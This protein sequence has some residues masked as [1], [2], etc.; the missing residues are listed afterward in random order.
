MQVGNEQ[1]LDDKEKGQCMSAQVESSDWS[2]GFQQG[3]IDPED[4]LQKLDLSG[5]D[6]WDPQLQQEV[7]D[8]I[9]E[10]ACIFS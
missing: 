4:I 6:D 8:L 2:A 3:W 5:I 10:Y 1:K 7:Q 9:H